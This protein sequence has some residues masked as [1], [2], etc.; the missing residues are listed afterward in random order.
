MSS[1]TDLLFIFGLFT[2]DSRQVNPDMISAC[3]YC[4][5]NKFSLEGIFLS[6]FLSKLLN[7][8]LLKSPR[9]QKEEQYFY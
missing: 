8:L 5:C 9:Y 6:S 1:N 7:S 3:D 4:F 2:G